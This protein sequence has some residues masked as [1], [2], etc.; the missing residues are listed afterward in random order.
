MEEMED[1]LKRNRQG[2]FFRKLRD[3]NANKVRP[4]PTILDE[5]GQPLKSKDEKLARWKRHF[6]GV[7][8]VQGTVTEEV[9]A[10]VE[11]LST[12]DAAELRKGGSGV[13]SQ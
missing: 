6:E 1:C 11:D 9:I 13:C 10:G 12:T 3:L 8:N 4:T 5:S 7:L 2:D